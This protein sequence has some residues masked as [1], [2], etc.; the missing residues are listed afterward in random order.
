VIYLI[1][2]LVAATA[3]LVAASVST[4]LAGRSRTVSQRL[5]DLSPVADQAAVATAERRRRQRLREQLQDLLR[6]LGEKMTPGRDQ[7][8]IRKRLVQAGHRG[9]AAYSMFMGT[10]VVL[11]VVLAVLALAYTMASGVRPQQVAV[12]AVVGALLGWMGPK[13]YLRRKARRRQLGIR[14]AMPDTLD[15]LV[16]CVEAGLGLNQALQRV[17][18]EIR[19]VNRA[20][21]ED[22]VLVNLE[23]RAGVDRTEALRNLAERTGVDDIRALTAMLIQTDRFGTSVAAALRTQ[24]DALRTRRRQ[25]AEEAAAKTTIK[26]VPPL[27]TCIFPAMFAVV[28]GPAAIQIMKFL[29]ELKT[30]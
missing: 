13:F 16:V 14:R 29:G 27:V 4:A 23:I 5:S 8:T 20:M 25:E 28:L 21:N 6:V 1:A 15:L 12:A 17:A 7:A 10:R 22:L 3:T 11:A 9:P 18:E 19:H 30:Q 26:L 2:L 24:S